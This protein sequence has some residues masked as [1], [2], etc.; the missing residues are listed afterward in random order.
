M[1]QTTAPSPPHVA[2]ELD[3]IVKRLVGL[4]QSF[5]ELAND[6]GVHL[7]QPEMPNPVDEGTQPGLDQLRLAIG[8]MNAQIAYIEQEHSR[9][10]AAR[11]Q[12]FGIG[13][14]KWHET[15]APVGHGPIQPGDFRSHP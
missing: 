13:D 4:R 11:A 3:M 8:Q 7:D 14:S 5:A 10:F 12:L 2:E 1:L 6:F 15:N 9:L